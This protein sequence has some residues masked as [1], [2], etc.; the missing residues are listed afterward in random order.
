MITKQKSELTASVSKS[1]G[2]TYTHEEE[3]TIKNNKNI[4]LNLISST[5][6]MLL[7]FTCGRI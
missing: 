1:K 7:V 2:N 3:K 4:V 5:F 6:D